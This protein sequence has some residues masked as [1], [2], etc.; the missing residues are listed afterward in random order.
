MDETVRLTACVRVF[1]LDGGEL[2]VVGGEHFGSDVS[3]AAAGVVD[4]EGMEKLDQPPLLEGREPQ[5]RRQKADALAAKSADEASR[6]VE[7][8]FEHAVAR[9]E[10]GGALDGLI[11]LQADMKLARSVCDHQ[12]PAI[13]VRSLDERRAEGTS[14]DGYRGLEPGWRRFQDQRG[15]RDLRQPHDGL[16]PNGRRGVRGESATPIVALERFTIL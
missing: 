10:Y 8:E 6:D 13:S 16:E 9:Q 5:G 1:P 4:V 3:W 11:V 2:G 7:P 15:R 14:V 12:F